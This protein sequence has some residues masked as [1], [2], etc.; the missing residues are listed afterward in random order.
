MPIKWI[1]LWVTQPEVKVKDLIIGVVWTC[2]S[3][4]Y[5]IIFLAVFYLLR[6][7]MMWWLTTLKTNLQG[8]IPVTD[9]QEHFNAQQKALLWA[10]AKKKMASQNICSRIPFDIRAVFKLLSK[11][12]CQCNYSDQSQQEQT[13]RWNNQN[14]WQLPVSCTKR[15]KNRAHKVRLVFVLALIS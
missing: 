15:G 14:F 10:L 8:K 2:S 1:T 9:S 6:F 11:N 4:R 3:S 7:V 5:N 12:D 13:A